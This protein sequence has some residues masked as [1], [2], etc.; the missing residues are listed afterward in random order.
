MSLKKILTYS[1]G[2]KA[3]NIYKKSNPDE[4]YRD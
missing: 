2:E 4:L 1:G 3:L